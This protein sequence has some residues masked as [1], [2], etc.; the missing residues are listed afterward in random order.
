MSI[1]LT[2]EGPDQQTVELGR[3]NMK[4]ISELFSK[5]NTD[6]D[7]NIYINKKSNYGF[8]G[9]NTTTDVKPSEL[10]QKN[11]NRVFQNN[12]HTITDSINYN[13][14]LTN[15]NIDDKYQEIPAINLELEQNLNS[16]TKDS[17]LNMNDDYAKFLQQFTNMK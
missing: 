17:L 11:N 12:I 3:L 4:K 15:N 10:I 1:I 8:G 16:K 7:G 6:D 9:G 13:N 2:Y 5:L 14:L